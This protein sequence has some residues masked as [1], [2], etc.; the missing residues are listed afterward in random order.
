MLKVN[1][2]EISLVKELKNM[3]DEIKQERKKK[4]KEGEEC[5]IF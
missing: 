3:A 5:V 1:L 2:K 4:R